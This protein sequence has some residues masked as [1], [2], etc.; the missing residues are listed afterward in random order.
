MKKIVLWAILFSL[1]MLGGSIGIHINLFNDYGWNSAFAWIVTI[2]TWIAFIGFYGAG[3][4]FGYLSHELYELE[5][6]AK[7]EAIERWRESRIANNHQKE[8]EK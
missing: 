4:R 1:L 6:K 7:R 5:N 3:Y 8:E 2:L